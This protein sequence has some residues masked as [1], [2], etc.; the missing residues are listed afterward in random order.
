MVKGKHG[1]EIKMVWYDSTM[2][3]ALFDEKGFEH[4]MKNLRPKDEYHKVDSTELFHDK[5]QYLCNKN[6]SYD[7]KTLDKIIQMAKFMGYEGLYF[8]KKECV[9]CYIKCEGYKTPIVYFILAPRDLTI[10]GRDP[11]PDYIRGMMKG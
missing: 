8:P 2:I 4:Y 10:E 5:S 6:T 11:V 9:P 1:N 3:M 7:K